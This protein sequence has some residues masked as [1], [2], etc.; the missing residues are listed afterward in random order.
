MSPT[1][2][3]SPPSG[4]ISRQNSRG[5]F[6]RSSSVNNGRETPKTFRDLQ[7]RYGSPTFNPEFF[8]IAGKTPLS[9]IDYQKT[10]RNS[11]VGELASFGGVK[12]ASKITGPRRRP[13]QSPSMRLLGMLHV[14]DDPEDPLT[15]STPATSREYMGDQGRFMPPARGPAAA[16]GGQGPFMPPTRG[17]EGAFTRSISSQL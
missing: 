15:E 12:Q 4:E 9:D 17:A 7:G 2:G 10:A 8:S 13:S 3:F 6:S 1:A 11:V 16:E 5:S 14:H